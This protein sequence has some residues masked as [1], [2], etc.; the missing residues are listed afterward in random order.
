MT[1]MRQ[2]TAISPQNALELLLL[3][4]VTALKLLAD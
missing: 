4:P 3:Q 2:G 1:H